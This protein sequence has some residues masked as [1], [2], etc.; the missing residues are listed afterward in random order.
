MC[1][2]LAS[3]KDFMDKDRVLALEN[4]LKLSSNS[5]FK[6]ERA[7]GQTDTQREISAAFGSVNKESGLE[8]T[9]QS[10]SPVERGI[11]SCADLFLVIL[12]ADSGGEHSSAW[13]QL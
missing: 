9:Q 3:A 4:A 11:L 13:Q 7:E 10:I 2:L 12:V 6:L 1:L 5:S 8:V